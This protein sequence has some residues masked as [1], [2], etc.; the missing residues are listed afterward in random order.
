MCLRCC[1]IELRLTPSFSGNDDDYD[2]V[3]LDDHFYALGFDPEFTG[4][5][6]GSDD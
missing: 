1:R 6:S 4:W 2:D 5:D 3:L